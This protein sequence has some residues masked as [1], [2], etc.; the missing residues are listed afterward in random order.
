M[1][2]ANPILVL[3]PEAVVAP[4]PPYNKPIV[5]PFQV[6]TVIVPNDVKLEVTTLEASVVLE[7]TSEV[8]IL[9]TFPAARSKCSVDV[10][11]SVASIQLSVFSVAP[12]IVIPAPLAVISVGDSTFARTIFLSSTTRV[13]V[14]RVVV[15]PLTIKSPVTVRLLLIV[16]LAGRLNVIAPAEAEAVISLLVPVID[17]TA[18]VD[19]SLICDPVIEIDVLPAAVI[20]PFASTVKVATEFAAP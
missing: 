7:R 3:A 2:I 12:R 17:V 14:L 13:D 6:P 9:N 15:F 11:A 16:T 4:V 8:P 10:Q 1:P 19:K 18:A 20:L 5:V